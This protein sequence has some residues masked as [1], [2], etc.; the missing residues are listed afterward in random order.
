[1]RLKRIALSSLVLVLIGLGA[2]HLFYPLPYVMTV[3]VD[4]GPDYDDFEQFPASRISTGPDISALPTALRADIEALLLSHPRIEAVDRFIDETDSYALL[5]AHQGELVYER[6]A[7]G[8]DAQSVQNSF[9]VSK[10]IA[11]ALVGI[12]SVDDAFA[13]QDAVTDHLPSLAERDARFEQITIEHLLNMRSGIAYSRDIVFPIINNHD[14]MVYYHPDL[15]TVVLERTEI[16]SEPGPFKYNNFNPPLLGLIIRQTTGTTVSTFLEQRIWRRIGTENDAGWT[17]DQ[18]DLE[19]MESGFHATARDLL[20][21]GLLYLNEGRHGNV[22]IIPAEWVEQTT[23][24]PEPIELEDY[25]G[26]RWSYRLGWWIIPRPSGPS[27]FCAIG[28]FGQFIYVSPQFQ[29]V[30]VRSGPDQGDWGDRD[31]TELFYSLSNQLG[32]LDSGA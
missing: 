18:H 2:L 30:I 25:D 4:Q 10:S 32:E 6:Y 23:D 3:M 19:R 15:E 8:Q 11:S 24:T 21:F 26:R 27:D 14:P 7:E 9:S 28:M 20:R 13:V 16:E 31:W 22:Q 29:T 17:T 12:A 5:I 1:M